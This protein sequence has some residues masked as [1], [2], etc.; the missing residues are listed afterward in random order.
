MRIKKLAAAAAA[1]AMSTQA[2]AQP[3]CL[4]TVEA[5]TMIQAM[6]PALIENISQQCA[7]HLSDNAALIA[8][9]T[10]LGQRYTPAAEAARPEAAGLAL[11]ILDDGETPPIDAESGGELILGI[12]EMGIAVALSDSMDAT[13]CPVAD[14]VFTAL[15]PLPSRNFASLLTLLIEIGSSEDEDEAD[16]GPFAICQTA[17]G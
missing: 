4:T 2:T 10:A 9:S 17:T 8:R 7:A 11:R 13:S 3:A 6:L 15:E 14:R 16:P 12:F 5:E 1:L